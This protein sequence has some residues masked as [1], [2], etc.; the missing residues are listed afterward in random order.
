MVFRLYTIQ[1][2][3]TRSVKEG[4]PTLDITI[5]EVYSGLLRQSRFCGQPYSNDFSLGGS[6]VCG[7][8]RVDVVFAQVAVRSARLLVLSQISQVMRYM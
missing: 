1:L 3:K 6:H 4:Q 8:E 5:P 7:R 2:S